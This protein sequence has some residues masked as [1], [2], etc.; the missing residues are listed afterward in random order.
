VER[1]PRQNASTRPTVSLASRRAQG[2]EPGGE[3]DSIL[4]RRG[5]QR[6]DAE[7]IAPEKR[8]IAGIQ[9]ER[10]HAAHAGQRRGTFAREQPQH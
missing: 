1:C 3:R 2:A 8:P 5:I 4:R 10:E 6:F 9:R 7:A